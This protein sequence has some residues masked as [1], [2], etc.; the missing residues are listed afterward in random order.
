MTRGITEAEIRSLAELRYQI[1]KFIQDGDATARKAGLEPQQYLLLLALRGLPVGSEASIRTLAERLS[2]QHHSAV[3]LVDRMEQ[4]GYVKRNRSRKDRRQVLV[5]L[6]SRGERLL[7]KV[8]Q[9]RLVE[10]RTNGQE[11]VE[12]I[13]ALIE[14]P[15]TAPRTHPRAQPSSMRQPMFRK[16]VISPKNANG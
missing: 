6:E 14:S 8:A 13:S 16:K 9:I 3:E 7:Q 12:A 10:L 5:S 15:S 2:L 1:R 11:L 4:H